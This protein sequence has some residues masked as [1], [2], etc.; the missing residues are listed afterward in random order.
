MADQR[1]RGTN[2]KGGGPA[3]ALAGEPFSEWSER[4]GDDRGRSRGLRSFVEESLDDPATYDSLDPSG[5]R[6]R[7][8]G[9][10]QQCRDAWREAMAWDLPASL[11]TPRRVIVVGM[12]G[13]A[14]GADI[15]AEVASARSAVPVEVRRGPEP[16]HTDPDT[17]LIACSYSGDTSE[18]LAAFGGAEGPGQRLVI[19]GG[20]ALA[21]MAETRRIPVLRFSCPGEPRSALGYGVFLLLGVLSRLRVIPIDEHEVEQVAATMEADG[22]A[23][24]PTSAYGANAAKQLAERL[25]GGIPIVFGDGFLMAAARRWQ[26][27]FNENSKQW[28]FSAALPELT[29]NLIEGFGRPL[30]QLVRPLVLEGA[31]SDWESSRRADLVVEQLD[32]FDASCE[33]VEVRAATELGTLLLACHLGDWVSLYLAALNGVDP[34]I[35]PAISWLKDR[36]RSE[37]AR[38]AAV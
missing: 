5:I 26:N 22:A 30:T 21:R 7:I 37:A 15:V 33:R 19:T 4:L 10:P 3:T 29:H 17:L 13:S 31:T 32:R 35:V 28:A 14:I 12:G 38:S 11:R 8:A 6:L 25:H 18:V 34:A 20:G 1:R 36:L 23:W 24:L 2:G 27:Q 16:P 9:L